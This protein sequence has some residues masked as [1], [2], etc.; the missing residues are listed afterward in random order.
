ML[1][2]IEPENV[3]PNTANAPSSTALSASALATPG[4]DWV[5]STEASSFWPRM[6]PAAL[7]SL[8]ASSTPFLKLVP[9]VARVPDSSW[10]TAILTSAPAVEA[11]TRQASARAAGTLD[12]ITSSSVRCCGS[13]PSPCSGQPGDG[14]QLV[15]ARPAQSKELEI[16]RKLLEQHI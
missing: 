5:S 4:L 12:I 14:A 10:I 6:P 2:T 16:E 7:I 13:V 8:T 15:G 9:A 1:T 3:G 11:T